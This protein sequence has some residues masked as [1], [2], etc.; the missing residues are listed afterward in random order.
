VSAFVASIGDVRIVKSGRQIAA[1]SC[2]A[3]PD[4]SCPIA[5]VG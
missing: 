3:R 1:W 5:G 4:S 2:R